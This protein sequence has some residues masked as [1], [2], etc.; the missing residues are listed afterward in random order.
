MYRFE[1]WIGD[2][3]IE[4]STMPICVDAEEYEYTP[5]ID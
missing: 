1:G 5:P 4:A 3:C 2:D